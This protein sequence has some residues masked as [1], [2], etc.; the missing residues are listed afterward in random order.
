MYTV[1][2]S[3]EGHLS[4]R[5]EVARGTLSAPCVLETCLMEHKHN[6]ALLISSSRCSG[7][8]DSGGSDLPVKHHLQLKTKEEVWGMVVWDLKGEEGN[9]HTDGKANVW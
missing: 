6:T 1:A 4:T 9:S 5:S 8:S 3:L 2:T 7:G